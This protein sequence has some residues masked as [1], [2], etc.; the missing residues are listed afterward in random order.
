MSFFS[1]NSEKTF[2]QT[3]KILEKMQNQIVNGINVSKKKD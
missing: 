1:F 3:V 2:S